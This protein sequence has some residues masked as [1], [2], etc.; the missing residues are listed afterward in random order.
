MRKILLSFL[1]VTLSFFFIPSLIF[2]QAQT[3]TPTPDQSTNKRLDE[4]GKEIAE[5]E[6]KVRDAQGKIKTLSSQISVMNNQIRLTELR[7]NQTKGQLR[8]LE[9]DIEILKKK[10]AS[11]E[12][13]L[14]ELSTVLLHR[15]VATYKAGT[16]EPW[17][18]I[19]SSNGFSDLLSRIQYIRI[20][21]VQGKKL[22]YDTEQAKSDYANQKDVFE[23]KQKELESLNK[24]LENYTNQ[25][26]QQKKDKETLLD[27]TRGDEKTF[28]EQLARARAEQAAILG[29]VAGKGEE[30]FVGQ[31]KTG[32]SVGGTITGKSACSSGS[33][34][35][36]E[37]VKDGSQNDPISYLKNI[38]FEGKCGSGNCFDYGEDQGR[39]FTPSGS[40]EWPMDTPIKINQDY[41][42]TYWARTGWYNGGPHTGLDIFRSGGFSINSS[43]NTKAVQDGKLYRG[44]IACGGGTLLYA[45]VEH[46][47]STQTYY[48]HIIPK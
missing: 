32:D 19:I 13:S 18:L 27:V 16:V 26:A 23:K 20:L 10:I 3:P 36:F 30:T 2:S 48:L 35:H 24:Q 29:I 17:Q 22:I 43:A 1:L 7:I 34:L 44:S 21:Q 25:L 37:V 5:L 8:Q 42:M 31:I 39:Y 14:D 28:Q 47:G 46:S 4:L 41:G 6:A 15:I 45:K 12:T 40:W 11:L 38:G 33:H 9:N